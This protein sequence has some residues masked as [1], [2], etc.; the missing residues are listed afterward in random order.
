MPNNLRYF[1]IHKPYGYLSQFTDN[2]KAKNKTL[3]ELYDFPGDVYPV[4]RLDKD[5]E[6]LLIITNDKGLNHR[7]L[8]PA[9]QHDR[10]YW[11]QVHGEVSQKAIDQLEKGVSIRIDSKDYKTRP[12]K[13]KMLEPQPEIP[14]R[15][16]PISP[17][18]GRPV[19]W[20]ELSL[21]EGKN[22]Q[23]RKMTAAVDL[24]CLRL[25]RVAIE[26]LKIDGIGRGEVKEFEREELYNLLFD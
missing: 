19:P 13:A 3:S 15:E 24:P 10:T 6:G 11:A 25:I 2:T 20:I 26:N 21:I 12:A 14:Q 8:N 4:G 23:V 5:S 1:V 7:L 18:G 17:R 16:K 22:R 9:F